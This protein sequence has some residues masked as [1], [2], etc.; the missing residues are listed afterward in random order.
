MQCYFNSSVQAALFCDN[1]PGFLITIFACFAV[2]ARFQGEYRQIV[3]NRSVRIE[4][5]I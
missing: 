3:K 5:K 2:W 1:L 4:E